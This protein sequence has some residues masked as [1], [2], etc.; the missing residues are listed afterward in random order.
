LILLAVKQLPQSER[1][2][3][4]G[5]V[6]AQRELPEQLVNQAQL[7]LAQVEPRVQQVW[8]VQ[9]VLKAQRV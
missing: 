9:L 5:Q 3:Q 1:L 4:L 6:E 7:V 2:A 8:L